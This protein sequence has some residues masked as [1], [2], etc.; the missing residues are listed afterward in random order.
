[1]ALG[2]LLLSALLALAFASA[3]HAPPPGLDAGERSRAAADYGSLPLSFEANN[4]RTDRRAD[5]ISRGSGYSLFLT[6]EGAVLD[7]ETPD[8]GAHVLRMGLAGADRSAPVAGID[9]LPGEVNSLVGD[10]PSNWKT[11]IPAYERVRY[12][13]VYPGVDVDWYGRQG[14]LEYDFRLAPGADANRIRMR[15]EG[16]DSLR[17]AANGDLLVGASSRTVRQRAPVAFQRIGGE[18]HGVEAAFEIDGRTVSFRLGAYDRT[19]PL[20][21]DP[22]VLG[23]ST[24]LGGTLG[25]TIHDIE[26]DPA[27]RAAYVGGWTH[28]TDFPTTTGAY[29]ETDPAAGQTVVVSKLN[30]GGTDLEYSTY[31]GGTDGNDTAENLDLDTSTGELAVT[32]QTTSTD[33]PTT[34]GAFDE[35]YNTNVDAYATILDP[36]GGGTGDLVY[37]TY[38][39]GTAG[40]SGLDVQF[41]SGGLV[42]AGYAISADFPTTDGVPGTELPAYDTTFNGGSDVFVTRLDPAGAGAADLNYSTYVGGGGLDQAQAIEGDAAGDI[43][44]TGAAAASPGS[45]YPTF[46]ATDTFDFVHGNVG[47]TGPQDGFLSKLDPAAGTGGLVYSGFIGGIGNDE[48]A[49]DLAVDAGGRAYVTGRTNSANFNVSSGAYDTTL[50]GGYDAFLQVI[51]AAGNTRAYSTF[52]GGNST[53]F[54]TGLAVDGAGDAYLT[55]LTFS[56]DLP[57]AAGFDPGYSGGQDG[58]LAKLRPAADGAADFLVGTYL[59]G[60]GSDF[61]DGVALDPSGNAYVTG[62]TASSDFPTSPGAYD[63][64][65]GGGGLNDGFITKLAPAPA[66]APSPPPAAAAAAAPAPI[67]A[68]GV[69]AEPAGGTVLV[70]VPGS[71]GFVPLEQI[72]VIPVGSIVDARNGFVKI[73]AQQCDGAIESAT[74][75]DGLFQVNQGGSVGCLLEA[76]LVEPLKCTGGNRKA[77]KPKRATSASAGPLARASASST[78]Q[79][80]GKGNGRF[81]TTGFRGSATVRGTEWLTLDRCKG[82]L[83][84]TTFRLVEGRL[85]I[86]D[87]GIKGAVNTLLRRG[88]YVAK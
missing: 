37:S 58:Y 66:P 8:G 27:T 22:Q 1:M 29:D 53:D 63:S 60:T 6:G 5:F 48:L 77:K 52:F 32:G 35:S 24:F 81:K 45:E 55:G 71:G 31:F 20:V 84:S 15:I 50:D 65:H 79:L 39:G 85:A 33:F 82:R 23:Y 62:S 4:G 38:L 68:S 13:G 72:R 69:I 11:G 28:A 19:E 16:A 88:K 18:R 21:I 12:S 51:N 87:F 41:D 34:S 36:A 9:R 7:L 78:R 56:T 76:K 86:D 67:F 40:D 14:Q 83:R 54:G 59:G 57:A 47:S 64:T 80:W 61:T 3:I 46:E 42:V 26:V 30:P 74:F 43:Y 73:T 10:D 75:W 17:L 2:G 49:T 70:Q 44:L 25:D